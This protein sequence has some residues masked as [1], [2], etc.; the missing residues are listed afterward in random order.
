MD[1]S[2]SYNMF[3]KQLNEGNIQQFS[4]KNCEYILVILGN[5]S[6]EKPNFKKNKISYRISVTIEH[7]GLIENV[8]HYTT[9]EDF[10]EHFKFDDKSFEELWAELS[11]A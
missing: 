4:Y 1:E 8:L 2:Y 6:T 11:L 10:V 9:V 3:I 5:G 7:F